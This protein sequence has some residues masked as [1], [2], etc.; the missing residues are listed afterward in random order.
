MCIPRGKAWHG[1]RSSV[2]F[3]EAAFPQPIETCSVS[4]TCPNAV[5]H[6]PT[7]A[8]LQGICSWPNQAKRLGARGI[9]P[10]TSKETRR[11]V[12][13]SSQP[14]SLRPR[15]CKNKE[16]KGFEQQQSP[17]V[18]D[19]RVF[20]PPI[21]QVSDV[22]RSPSPPVPHPESQPA[23]RRSKVL[24]LQPH[25]HRRLLRTPFLR[26]RSRLEVTGPS[27]FTN[28]CGSIPIYRQEDFG[29]LGF[30]LPVF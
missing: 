9:T 4:P 23:N 5:P 3:L 27:H 22:L 11:Q 21:S 24:R 25:R 2:D 14:F 16:G 13:G 30:P 29:P 7:P 26:A 28:V 12:G 20:G 8:S 19:H 17:T 6:L 15:G 1:P 10:S 18:I